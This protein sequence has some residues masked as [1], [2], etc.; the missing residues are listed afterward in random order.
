M[1]ELQ[2]R[3]PKYCGFGYADLVVLPDDLVCCYKNKIP[4]RFL[5]KGL[6]NGKL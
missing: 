5:R 3:L 4:S 2:F 1:A 6:F